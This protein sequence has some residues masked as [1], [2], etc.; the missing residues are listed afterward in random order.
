MLKFNPKLLL[1]LL[2]VF[3]FVQNNAQ[4]PTPRGSLEVSGRI[5]IGKNQEKLTRKRFF[6]LR[7]G[8]EKNKTLI[9]KLKAAEIV[10]RDCY[11]TQMKASSQYI[12][13]LQ[14]E[15]CESPYCRAITD[16]DIQ[17]VP[18]FL[19]AYQKGLRQFGRRRPEIAQKWLTTNLEPKLRD[20]YY[21]RLK[22]LLK[23]LLSGIKP[24]QSS[25]TD[26]VTVKAIFIDIPLD[27]TG[28]GDKKKKE[29]TFLVSN[30]LPFE[31]G[32][33]SYIWACEVDIGANKTEKLRLEDKSK[34][35]CEVIIKDLQ[36]CKTEECKK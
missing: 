1:I 21:Q 30:I 22:V 4:E 12:C 16:S 7:G 35:G 20:G 14:A 17:T 24:L 15:T 8:L 13:W 27:L 10:S 29:E 36:V 28:E 18:E 34:K 31:I 19:T 5:K 6:L 32:D 9:E 2:L 25:M 23:N 11:Y 33:K 3:G 26:T